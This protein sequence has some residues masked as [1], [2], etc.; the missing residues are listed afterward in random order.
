M[1][2]YSMPVL[3]EQERKALISLAKIEVKRW[4][5]CADQQRGGFMVELM[6]I[7]LAALNAEPVGFIRPFTPFTFGK[8]SGAIFKDETRHYYRPVYLSPP[9][10]VKQEGG[11]CGK[12]K[13]N[14]WFADEMGMRRC[15]MCNDLVQEGEHRD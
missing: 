3:S 5:S 4:K 7:A 15:F 10:P 9:V 12:C 14:G 1:S 13:G 6:E 11:Q 8:S 2:D